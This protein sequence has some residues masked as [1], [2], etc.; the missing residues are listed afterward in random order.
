MFYSL[1]SQG[2]DMVSDDKDVDEGR[3]FWE[4][5]KIDYS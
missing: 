1:K 5:L 4:Y 2:S 3:L